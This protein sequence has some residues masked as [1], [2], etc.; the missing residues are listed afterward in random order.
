MWNWLKPKSRQ[1]PAS[2]VGFSL[3]FDPEKRLKSALLCKRAIAL[4]DAGRRAEALST[5]Q[6]AVI[7][8]PGYGMAWSDFGI[9]LTELE[10]YSE[11]AEALS[12]ACELEPRDFASWLHRAKSCAA[13]GRREEARQHLNQARRFGSSPEVAELERRLG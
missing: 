11:A 3:P 8:D 9:C 4:V 10:R 1:T 5:F 6:E 12:K 2:P 7:A 13:L